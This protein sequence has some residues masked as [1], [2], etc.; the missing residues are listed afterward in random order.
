MF[1][2]CAALLVAAPAQAATVGW[3]A[4]PHCESCW[5]PAVFRALPGERNVVSIVHESSGTVVIRDAGAPLVPGEA[6]VAIEGGVRCV[7]RGGP[8]LYLG[9]GDD[10]AD[11]SGYATVHGE[12]GDDRITG[13]YGIFSGGPGDDVVTGQVLLDDDGPT[14]GR[15]T[16]VGLPRTFNDGPR[17]AEVRYTSRSDDVRVD[18]RPGRAS[19]D[20][21]TGVSRVVGGQGD[22][23]LIGDDRAN[24]LSGGPG[25]DRVVGL[26][27]DDEVDGEDVSAGAGDDQVL[28]AGT[29]APRCGPG[30]DDVL[31]TG[32]SLV[33]ADC[34]GIGAGTAA[35]ARPRMTLREAGAPFL[36]GLFAC[37]PDV[38]KLNGWKAKAHGRVVA[39][40]DRSARTLGLNATGRRLL[41]RTGRLRLQITHTATSNPVH[42]GEPGRL[43]Q[44]FRLDVRLRENG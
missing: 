31:V 28:A 4:Q 22:D 3:E 36:L 38:C 23:V 26:G 24:E 19:E 11:S 25:S 1:V 14:V 43:H 18:L 5:A 10:V 32:N 41:R 42:G 33:G 7:N 29:V 9:D 34:E 21:L 20:R 6:C 17:G 13:D 30:T 44:R 2:T 39:S 15:D 12:A 16:Y 35:R 27:G 37:S 8:L 40:G